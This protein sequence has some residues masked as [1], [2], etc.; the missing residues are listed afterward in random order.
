M[1]LTLLFDPAMSQVEDD[2]SMP[3]LAHLGRTTTS[4]IFVHPIK[5]S[6]LHL[7]ILRVRGLDKEYPVEQVIGRDHVLVSTNN[8]ED[9][10]MADVLRQV[11]SGD[12]NLTWYMETLREVNEGNLSEA[13]LEN[14]LLGVSGV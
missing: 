5:W 12:I 8:I 9:K 1:T 13:F 6:K 3:L 4:P 14:S 7:S 11:S 2:L 10:A